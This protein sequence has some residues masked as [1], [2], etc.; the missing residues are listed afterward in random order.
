VADYQ[1]VTGEIHAMERLLQ[2]LACILLSSV[3]A[4]QLALATPYRGKLTDDSVNGRVMKPR[5]SLIY[6]GTV[7]LDATGEYE[8]NTAVIWINGEP[9]KMID[10]FPVELNVCDGDLIEIQLKK[11][12]KP[13]YVFLTSRKG[14]IK[15]DLKAS[16]ILVDAGINRLF[17]VLYD[18]KS[19]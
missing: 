18:L 10:A 11:G 7:T 17:R 3:I 4:L 6:R 14:D 19:D 13:F 2:A 16:T 1:T 5:E 12:Q 15:T 9:K 8:P